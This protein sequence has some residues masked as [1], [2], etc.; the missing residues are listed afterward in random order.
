MKNILIEE[1]SAVSQ[2]GEGSFLS[3]SLEGLLT[4]VCF[5]AH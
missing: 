5:C 2:P 4:D 1:M 3:A